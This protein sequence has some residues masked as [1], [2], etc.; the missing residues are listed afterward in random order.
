MVERLTL[1]LQRDGLLTAV[2]AADGRHL[3]WA[4]S[5]R[6]PH[7]INSLALVETTLEFFR[8]YTLQVLT[9][10][11]PRTSEWGVSGGMA[12]LI[13]AGELTSLC[14]GSGLDWP[15]FDRRQARANDID[16]GPVIFSDQDP[17]TAAFAI[18]KEVYVR[19]GIAPEGIPYSEDGRVAERLFPTALR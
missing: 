10:A 11:Q 18:L 5:Q 6:E 1:S 2:I 15:H 14:V 4:A 7:N 19:F 17:G 13:E 16:F 3:A 8:L 9:R 12:D